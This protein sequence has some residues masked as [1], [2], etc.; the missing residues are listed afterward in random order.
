MNA[1]KALL[2]L[3]LFLTLFSAT[4]ILAKSSPPTKE[5]LAHDYVITVYPREAHDSMLVEQVNA[6]VSNMHIAKPNLN[7][8]EA[9]T[10]LLKVMNT[11]LSYEAYVE[12]NERVLIDIFNLQEIQEL[13]KLV[14]RPV[15]KKYISKYYPKLTE[16]FVQ[17]NEKALT[18]LMHEV[19]VV[20]DE[21]VTPEQVAINE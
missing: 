17:Y 12:M 13:T 1:K 4:S 2:F 15:L 3:S 14:E 5:K 16:E 19:T 8:E 21:I 18:Q 11:Y 10:K 20:F 6:L 9:K 7:V